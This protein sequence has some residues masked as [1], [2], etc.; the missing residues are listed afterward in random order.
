MNPRL[1]ILEIW[2]QYHNQGHGKLKKTEYHVIRIT[3]SYFGQLFGFSD[4]CTTH[5]F[6][7]AESLN[8]NWP[9]YILNCFCIQHFHLIDYFRLSPLFLNKRIPW[10]SKNLD[11]INKSSFYEQCM[12]KNK[13]CNKTQ[14]IISHIKPTWVSY[15][16][17]ILENKVHHFNP[18]F[19]KNNYYLWKD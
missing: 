14:I 2:V 6:I 13:L 8:K 4:R 15:H 5:W 1:W 19:F 18:N 12:L 9:I 17:T 16:L 3:P 10:L 7:Y 11:A